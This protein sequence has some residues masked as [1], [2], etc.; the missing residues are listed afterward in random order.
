MNNE[1]EN[2]I[3]KSHEEV[4]TRNARIAVDEVQSL[5]KELRKEVDTMGLVINSQAQKIAMLEQRI[6]L[7]LTKHF[8]GGST[9]V[10]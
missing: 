2:A 6:N 5:R 9:E 7:L 4:A 3:A 10:A 1:S 8:T